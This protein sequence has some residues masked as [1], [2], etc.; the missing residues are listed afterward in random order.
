MAMFVAVSAN[1]EVNGETVFSIVDGMGVFKARAMD[2]LTKSGIKDP[3]PGMWFKQ[4]D[5]LNAFK[6]ISTLLGPNT[7]FSIG[8]KIPENAKFP[9]QIDNIEK[10]IA[11]I[12]VAY[13]MNHRIDGKVLFDTN[14]GKMAEGIGHYSFT[15]I[16]EKEAK[17]VCPNPYPCDFDRGLIE[18]TA[19]KFM[20]N[21][22]FVKVTHNDN[23][24]C[25]KK[26][27]DSCEYIVTW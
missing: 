16:S 27:A 8:K 3:K 12:D 26:G 19:K 18:G 9:P 4:Q 1:A 24:K 5:W 17:M 2:I 7:L 11:A 14:T 20:K 15:K 22:S 6:E 10:A 23:A 25:R 21:G 13:H